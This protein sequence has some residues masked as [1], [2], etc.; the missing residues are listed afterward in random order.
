M[1]VSTVHISYCVWCS[2]SVFRYLK[3]TRITYLFSCH[4]LLSSFTSCCLFIDAWM[5]YLIPQSLIQ[6]II[7]R[8]K[9]LHCKTW[10][11]FWNGNITR[12]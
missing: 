10:Q 4:Q 5:H 9:Y 7:Y 11:R 12:W 8:E 3:Y 1:C 6:R 2:G